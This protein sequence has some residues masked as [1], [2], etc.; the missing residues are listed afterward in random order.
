[1]SVPNLLE[2]SHFDRSSAANNQVS[3]VQSEERINF[4]MIAGHVFK[5]SE[6]VDFKPALLTKVVFGAPLQVDLSANFLIKERLTLGAAYRWDAAWSAMAGFQLSDSLMV[7][8]GYD[9]ETT[10]LQAFNDGSF[11]LMLRFELFQKYSRVI[12]PRFF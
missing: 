10:D 8:F 4:Y 1:M 12:T 9:R 7:G 6:S 5:L 11:E 2:T 3:N